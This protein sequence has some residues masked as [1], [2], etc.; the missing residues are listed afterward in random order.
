[1][2]PAEEEE[3]DVRV[4]L[5]RDAAWVEGRLART[6]EGL[7]QKKDE[8][9]ETVEGTAET[10]DQWLR[11]AGVALAVAGAIAWWHS[12]RRERAHGAR[13]HWAALVRVWRHPTR[14]AARPVPGFA[15]RLLEA[16][17]VGLVLQVGAGFMAR[18]LNPHR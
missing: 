8:A 2:S 4:Q 14:L 12:S 17:A 15:T 10:A 11:P 16:A 3:E 18:S 13:E 7:G 5:E 1:M 9:V 6:L